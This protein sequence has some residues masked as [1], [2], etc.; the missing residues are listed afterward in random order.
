M[1][2]WK[3][4][5][6]KLKEEAGW[7]CQECGDPQSPDCNLEVHHIH[8]STGSMIWEYPRARVI[9]VCPACHHDRQMI[10]QRI[11][12]NV[13]EILRTK[14]VLEMQDQPI[15]AFFSEEEINPSDFQ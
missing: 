2:E 8:Y 13:A 1:P 7:K 15:Y 4:F 6:H 3:R 10:E 5:S 11:L 14:N 12:G 9:V